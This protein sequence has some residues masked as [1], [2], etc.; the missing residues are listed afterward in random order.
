MPGFNRA[1]VDHPLTCGLFLLLPSNG[2]SNN[3]SIEEAAVVVS[4]PSSA[5]YQKPIFTIDQA[6]DDN[7]TSSFASSDEASPATDCQTPDFL[8]ANQI[9]ESALIGPNEMD[10]K[11]FNRQTRQL[12]Q[13]MSGIHLSAQDR[14]NQDLTIATP[15]E[16]I[17]RFNGTRVINKILISNNGIAAVK[18]M[19]SIRRWSYEIFRNERAIRFVVMVSGRS[20]RFLAFLTTILFPCPTGYT[21]R[22]EGKR[23]VH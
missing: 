18:C 14:D 4:S 20:F 11:R 7:E 16:F 22:F 3:N 13:S 12:R 6:P 1:F 9:L 2:D 19:R 5:T 8:H 21:G 23:R 10:A 15:E 17:K